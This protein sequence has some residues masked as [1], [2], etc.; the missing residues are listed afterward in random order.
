MSE[1]LFILTPY[2]AHW[3]PWVLLFLLFCLGAAFAVNP[4]GIADAFRTAF[5]PIERRYADSQKWQWLIPAYIFHLSVLALLVYW[6]AYAYLAPSSAEWT[7]T[8]FLM[9]L[10]IVIGVELL[11]L[12]AGLMLNGIFQLVPHILPVLQHYV[13]M[14]VAVC[15]VLYVLMLF[16]F[17][18]H[19]S[20]WIGYGSGILCILFLIALSVKLFRQFC[21]SVWGVLYIV[22]YI[23]T[24]EILPVVG[25]LLFIARYILR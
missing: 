14:W 15:L 12:L 19:A 17:Y 4:E 3:T 10:L 23:V 25:M 8:G 5:K 6:A 16:G 24:L 7:F 20:I 1:Q 2:N 9:V 18:G 21:H 13:H 11:R 22:L